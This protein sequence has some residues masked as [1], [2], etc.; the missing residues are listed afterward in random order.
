M[1]ALPLHTRIGLVLTALAAAVLLVLGL[2]WTRSVQASI[3]EEVE[4]AARVA[5]QWL[6]VLAGETRQAGPAPL[7]ARIAAVG[8]IR[9]NSLEVLGADG[10]R[11]YHSPPSGYKAG[12]AAPAF[13]AGL[14]EP[15]F[16]PRRIPAGDL[17]LVL[18]PDPSRAT[19]DAW[20][21]LCALA[22]WALGLL[23]LLFLGCRLALH[24][25]LAPLGRLMA[26][27]DRT[28]NGRF[29]TRLPAAGAPELARLARAFNGM[30]DRL[31]EA[32]DENVRHESAREVARRLQGRLEDER[33]DIA[34]ELHDELAQG[35]TAVRA[36]AGAIV[37]RSAAEPALAD[38][39]RSIVAVTGDIQDGVRRILH[40]LREPAGSS[41]AAA[42]EAL[43]DAW[44]QRHPETVL[45]VNLAPNPTLE[46]DDLPAPFAQ[47]VL[48]IAQEGLTNIARHARASRA[49]LSLHG[50]AGGI[51]LCLTDDGIGAAALL[52]SA[53]LSS[54]SPTTSPAAGCGLGLA[55][56]GERIAA[57]GGRLRLDTPP[58]GG[59]RIRAW[60]PCPA[61]SDTAPIDRPIQ[62]DRP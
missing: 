17:T 56:M 39:A 43:A 42:L 47:A 61:L 7:L 50:E 8:R 48:R 9:A 4:A 36:L 51:A 23:A 1:R 16:A 2:V 30:A 32:V 31:A 19:L 11:L 21:G 38:H 28:G 62:E 37:Q 29:D 45:V 49:E 34:R 59:F 25:A 13:F 24:R 5:E 6:K 35:I 20:D 41:L 55:G 44:R 18:S 53:G 10:A 27:L 57:L 54:A 33:R 60:L 26:A 52:S 22:G 46:R 14:V 15:D 12:R 58:E 40:R 3:H